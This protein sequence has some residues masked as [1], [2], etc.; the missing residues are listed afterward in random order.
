M[1]PRFLQ[2]IINMETIDRTPV[3]THAFTRKIFANMRS[4]WGD[5][6]IPPLT[7]PMLVQPAAGDP[8]GAAAAADEAAVAPEVAADEAAPAAE[9]QQEPHQPPDSPERQSSPHPSSPGLAGRGEDCLS[10]ESCGW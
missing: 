2:T 5:Q 7:P 1:Y 8:A 9:A 4:R 6:A 3:P 10:G